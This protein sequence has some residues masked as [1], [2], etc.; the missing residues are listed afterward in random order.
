MIDSMIG[1]KM[2]PSQ[3]VSK[4]MLRASTTNVQRSMMKVAV[5]EDMPPNLQ[6]VL[7]TQSGDVLEQRYRIGNPPQFR[8][9]HLAQPVSSKF[10]H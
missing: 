6:T 4:H 3:A 5:N 10:S 2:A 1:M 7:I 9:F 8:R